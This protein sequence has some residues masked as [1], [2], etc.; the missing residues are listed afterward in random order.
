MEV[1]F[2][3][4]KLDLLEIDPNFT[5]GYS[6]GV[7]KSYR[8]RM[9]LIRASPDER[10]FYKLKSLRFEKLEGKRKHQHSMRINDQYRLIVEL[11]QHSKDKVIKIIS[12]EDYH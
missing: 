3:D 4:E 2:G 1:E 7:V 11:L 9:Q 12:I 8:K 5:S 6:Q 10:D